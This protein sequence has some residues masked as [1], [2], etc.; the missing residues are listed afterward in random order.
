MNNKGRGWGGATPRGIVLTVLWVVTMSVAILSVAVSYD[1][2]DGS[3]T[4]ITARVAFRPSRCDADHSWVSDL[5]A[6]LPPG[7]VS[8]G[9]RI[10]DSSAEDSGID[11]GQR[12]EQLSPCTGPKVP[13]GGLEQSTG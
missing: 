8:R 10:V 13:K 5:E 4:L 7:K 9:E 6:A 12:R 11:G 2:N 3:A 1:P